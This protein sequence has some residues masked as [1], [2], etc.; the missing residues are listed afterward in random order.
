MKERKKERNRTGKKGKAWMINEGK[1]VHFAP[2]FQTC[3]KGRLT[4][5][6]LRFPKLY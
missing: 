1:N 6:L 4:E 2:P 3:P 5:F